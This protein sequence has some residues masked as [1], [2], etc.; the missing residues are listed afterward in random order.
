MLNLSS[1]IK[2]I[3]LVCY[4][5]LAL[6]T[7]RST[8]TRRV[9]VFFSIY[10]FGMLSWQAGSF[11]INFTEDPT[12]A[13]LLY[14]L[15]IASS[16][17]YTILF[18][19]FT[20]ALVDIRGQI[21]LARLSYVACAVQFISAVMGLQ[22][23]ELRFGRAGYWIP[24][25]TSNIMLILSG[26]SFGF[27][28][29]GFY[30]LLKAYLHE[31]SP[32][33]RNRYIYI[34]IG[35]AV[36]IIGASTNLTGLRDYPVDISANL[37]SA[38]IIGYAVVRHRL[39]DIRSI[40]ARS[41]FYSVL[42]ASLIAMYLVVIVAL[43]N[44]LAY[45]VGY[46]RSQYGILSIVILAILFLPVRNMMQSLLDKIFFRERGDYQKATQAFSRAI[47]SLYDPEP[48]LDLIGEAI[49]KNVKTESLSI[50]LFDTQLDLFVLRRTHGK[51]MHLDASLNP[52]SHSLLLKWLK[53]EGAIFHK[54]ELLL[55]PESRHIID[56]SQ[57]LLKIGRAHV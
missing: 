56:D 29:L 18:F 19:Q 28:G 40:L 3:A 4:L 44:F 51:E 6:L 22:L 33:K 50:F 20:R 21:V 38:L 2:G 10:L 1:A 31:T 9:R 55:D 42:T 41:L 53:K 15:M 24:V 32:V 54:E 25:Y 23:N 47:A 26:L 27:W 37:A 39:M 52:S 7:L 46:T 36:T 49:T 14:N 30:N 13:L 5:L 45:T 34:L 12:I 8:A 48:V 57:F 35:A 11:A 17:S 16:A 43:E